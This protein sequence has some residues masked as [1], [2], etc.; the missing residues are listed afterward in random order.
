M[1]LEAPR[2]ETSKTNR[3]PFQSKEVAVR[4]FQKLVIRSLGRSNIS[5]FL[6]I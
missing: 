5:A 6:V 2:L 3:Q 4:K 1:K